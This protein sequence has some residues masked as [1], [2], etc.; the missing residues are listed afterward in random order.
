MKLAIELSERM[1][2]SKP[3]HMAAFLKVS[4][5]L[6][7]RE[8][9]RVDDTAVAILFFCVA[10]NASLD[11]G[12]AKHGGALLLL[13]RARVFASGDSSIR[14]EL[15]AKTVGSIERSTLKGTPVS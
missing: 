2:S 12:R 15:D 3:A 5:V 9:D 6:C 1:E 4:F 11:L 14:P 13:Y 7:L 10:W 8:N